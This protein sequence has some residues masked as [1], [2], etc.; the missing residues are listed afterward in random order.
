M[1]G[2][3]PTPVSELRLSGTATCRVWVKHDDQTNAS[4]GGSK[5]RKLEALLVE[6]KER[7]AARILTIGAVGSHHVLATAIHG[8]SFGIPVAA[9]LV[10]QPRSSHVEATIRR[11]IAAGLSPIPLRNYA[12]VP[13]AILRHRQVS[14]Y[15]IPLGGS[16]KAGTEGYRLAALELE[17]Q[18]RAGE[19]PEPE[20]IVVALGSGGTAAGLAAGLVS[21]TLK[22]RVLAVAVSKPVF[23]LRFIL[24]QRLAELGLAPSLHAAARARLVIN[25]AFV[26]GGY[27][28][29][30]APGIAATE[31][32]AREGLTLDATYTAKA[33]AAAL[34]LRATARHVLY[35]HT[36]ASP[37][38]AAG[39]DQAATPLPP[40]VERLLR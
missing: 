17:A 16:C 21:T 9:L 38:A 4:Y 5:V 30:T 26:G 29:A 33:Y 15:W 34:M 25:D 3:Y 22:T 18:V 19:L 28:H 7:G 27:G 6:A 40:A 14:D 36:L 8:A 37:E 32:A 2:R 39:R 11:S 1:I 24:R 31:A 12:S 20:W 35:W 10:P 23:A 13:F